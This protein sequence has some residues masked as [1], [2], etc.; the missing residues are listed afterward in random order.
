MLI[1]FVL[2]QA[3]LALKKMGERCSPYYIYLY[4]WRPLIQMF[5]PK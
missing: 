1:Q 4:E 2:G 5:T 3:T